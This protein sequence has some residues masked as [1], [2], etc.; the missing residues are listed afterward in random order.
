MISKMDWQY[1]A[2]SYRRYFDI[3]PDGQ[4]FL[5]IGGGASA[6]NIATAPEITVVLE[7][8]EELK[9]RVPEP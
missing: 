1:N 6:E 8:F 7:W 9:A 5:G 2:G 4:R 3:S